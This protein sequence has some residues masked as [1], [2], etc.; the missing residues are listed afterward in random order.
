MLVIARLGFVGVQTQRQS[1]ATPFSA[2]SFVITD[3]DGNLVK[4]IDGTLVL[5]SL[6]A[7]TRQHER[8]MKRAVR[9]VFDIIKAQAEQI[10]E[11]TGNQTQRT[12]TPRGTMSADDFFAKALQAQAEGRIAALDVSRAEAFLGAGQPVPSEL[13]RQVLG[14]AAG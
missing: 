5:K 8:K 3:A 9:Q 2:A 4:A 1:G 14:D 10:A 11:L 6:D 7:R 12:A 13:V